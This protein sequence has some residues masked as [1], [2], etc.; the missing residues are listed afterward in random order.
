M[1]PMGEIGRDKMGKHKL[2]QV[3]ALWVKRLPSDPDQEFLS[4]IF[5]MAIP[6][7]TPVACYVNKFKQDGDRK[8]DYIVWCDPVLLA[9]VPAM[10]QPE[11]PF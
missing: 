2:V 4:G 9:E 7:G 10:A 3:G 1:S 11:H 5:E 6:A 8:P